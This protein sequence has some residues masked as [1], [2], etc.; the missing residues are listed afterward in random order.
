VTFG[1]LDEF[2]GRETIVMTQSVGDFVS[3]NNSLPLTMP[4]SSWSIRELYISKKLIEYRDLVCN[5]LPGR[6]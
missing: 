5:E 1:E 3:L 2:P 6:H 4:I